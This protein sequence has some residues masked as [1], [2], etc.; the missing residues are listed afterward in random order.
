MWRPTYSALGVPDEVQLSLVRPQ[1]APLGTHPEQADR[2]GIEELSQ[3]LV[4]LG[5]SHLT[6]LLHRLR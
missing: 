1:D 2:G 6:H 5:R 4:A 3:L